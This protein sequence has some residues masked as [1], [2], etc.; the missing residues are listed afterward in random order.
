M[1]NILSRAKIK[2]HVCVVSPF[3]QLLHCIKLVLLNASLLL[4]VLCH[5]LHPCHQMHPLAGARIATAETGDATLETTNHWFRL[6]DIDFMISAALKLYNLLCGCSSMLGNDLTSII[7]TVRVISVLLDSETDSF[8]WYHDGDLSIPTANE[9]ESI[10]DRV[11]R[12]SLFSTR[13]HTVW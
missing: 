10:V 6:P 12:L 1:V 4:P 2:W 13:A 3:L 11:Q 7:W 9:W 5:F 8:S